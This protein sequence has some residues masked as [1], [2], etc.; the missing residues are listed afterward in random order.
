MD[1]IFCKISKKEL[2]TNLVYEDEVVMVIMDISPICDGHLLVIPKNHYDTVF[3]LPSDVLDHMYKIA[4]K[5]VYL[6]MNKLGENGAT[7][8]FN[9][10]DKQAVKHVHMHIMPNFEIKASKSVE[11]VYKLLMED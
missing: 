8:A 9:Y 6:L 7:L 2:E 10:G 5:M 3:D 1:C 11:D 4:N